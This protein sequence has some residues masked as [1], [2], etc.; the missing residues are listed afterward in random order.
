[1]T[2][3]AARITRRLLGRMVLSMAML[4]S[5]CATQHQSASLVTPISPPAQTPPQGQVDIGANTCKEIARDLTK[6]DSD[7]LDAKL[8]LQFILQQVFSSL[9]SQMLNEAQRSKL[10]SQLEVQI[11]TKLVENYIQ[12]N[13]DMLSGRSDGDRYLCLVRTDLTE[14][15]VSY[16]EFELR[17]ID[18]RLQIVDWIDL[19]QEQRVS[20]MFSELFGDIGILMETDTTPVTNYWERSTP[21]D[22]LQFF[23][24]LQAARNE[25]SNRVFRAYDNL[26]WRFKQKPLYALLVVKAV[27]GRDDVLYQK[28]LKNFEQRFGGENHYGVLLVDLYMKEGR[29]KEAVRGLKKFKDRVGAD[30]VVEVLQAIMELDQGHI[31]LFYEHCLRAIDVNQDY[32]RTYWVLLD[33]LV[34]D[35][36][37]EDAVL[38]LNVLTKMFNFDLRVHH[39]EEEA[40][41]QRFRKS[42]EFRAWALSRA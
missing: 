6:H 5:A 8:N 14:Q 25:D 15:G 28:A 33:Q 36:N 27:S 9:N 20:E 10:V 3:Y 41:Y 2:N 1:M 11:R 37:Y 4:L 21:Q 42:D 30:P 34:A 13:W 31:E 32:E 7:A 17:M 35:Q 12:D 23:E 40:K 29:Y 26:P 24:F 16:V 18:G 22:R 19:V 39:F 38:V